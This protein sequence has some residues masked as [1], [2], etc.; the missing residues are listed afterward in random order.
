MVEYNYEEYFSRPEKMEH[1]LKK[2][3]IDKVYLKELKDVPT[4]NV[5][6]GI[7]S[8]LQ[9]PHIQDITCG[10]I[11]KTNVALLKKKG[12]KAVC[13]DARLEWPFKDHAFEQIIAIDVFEHLGQ[14]SGFLKELKRVSTKDG[15]VVVGLPLLNYWKNYLP[16]LLMSTKNVQYDEHPRMFFDS[17]VKRLFA[18]AGFTLEKAQYRGLKGYGYYVFRPSVK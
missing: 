16:L 15:V 8:R 14:V 2:A 1:A 4:L 13:F 9:T 5:G 18:E 12:I 7:T 11:S 6:S 3:E 10:D 17:D